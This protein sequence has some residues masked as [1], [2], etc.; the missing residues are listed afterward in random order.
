MFNWTCPF[1]QLLLSLLRQRMLL[2]FTYCFTRKCEMA[3]DLHSRVYVCVCVCVCVCACVHVC[4]CVC[5]CV[6]VCARAS[7]SQNVF[8]LCCSCCSHCVKAGAYSK[9]TQRCVTQGC[10]AAIWIGKCTRWSLSTNRPHWR[11]TAVSKYIGRRMEPTD[12]LREREQ[13]LWHAAWT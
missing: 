13:D 3:W 2:L 11:L 6:S 7:V 5:V 10:Q 9:C 8:V 4:V 12:P 1:T